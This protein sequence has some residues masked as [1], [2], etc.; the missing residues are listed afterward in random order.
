MGFM[1]VNDTASLKAENGA[2]ASMVPGAV[3]IA[4]AWVRCAR[5]SSTVALVVSKLPHDAPVVAQDIPVSM[6]HHDA[7]TNLSVAGESTSNTH[8]CDVDTSAYTS[9]SDAPESASGWV[10]LE[11]A[12]SSTEAEH[13]ITMQVIVHSHSSDAA[14]VIDDAS[15]EVETGTSPTPGSGSDDSNAEWVFLTTCA[16]VEEAG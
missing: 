7:M 10:Q 12:V 6:M 13:D 15:W 9:R 2:M 16:G 11:V 8:R 1:R 4:R 3:H 5:G 14:V